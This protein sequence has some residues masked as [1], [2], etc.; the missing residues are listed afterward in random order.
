[1][2][3]GHDGPVLLLP[4]DLVNIGKCSSLNSNQKKEVV[5]RETQQ[6]IMSYIGSKVGRGLLVDD[7]CGYSTLSN[8]YAF[9]FYTLNI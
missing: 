7:A 6:N 2:D 8:F 5:G 9:T 1:M 3:V 4:V